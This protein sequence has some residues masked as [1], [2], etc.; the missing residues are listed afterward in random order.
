MRRFG[1]LILAVLLA[2]ATAAVP[3]K[4][5]AHAGRYQPLADRQIVAQTAPEARGSSTAERCQSSAGL[6]GC[7]L[8]KPSL[9]MASLAAIN[10]AIRSEADAPALTGRVVP[11]SSGPPKPLSV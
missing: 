2:I 9:V 7:A 8:H 3:A 5:A 4:F 10:A 11:T 6:L 1:M